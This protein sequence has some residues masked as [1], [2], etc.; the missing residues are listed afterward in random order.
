[1][2]SQLLDW[3]TLLRV[4]GVGPKT[5]LKLLDRFET[6]TAVLGASKAEF[7]DQ[8]VPAKLQQQLQ[9]H[10]PQIAER[11]L[12]W[13]E[14][15]QVKVITL[16]DETY[17]PLLK[18]IHDPPP[19]LFVRGDENL[20]IEPQLAI[21]GSRHASA[22][23]D[24][25]A[26]MFAKALA[27][28]GI[29]VTSGLALGIDAAAHRGAL[30][31]G[32]TVAVLGTG[33]DQIYPK[34]HKTLMADVVEKGCVVSEFPIGTQPLPHNFPR[35]NRIISGLSLGTL[36]VEAAE[37]SGSLVTARMAMEQGREVFAI[38]GSVH[39]PVSRGCH[40][41]IKQGAKLVESVADILEE[42]DV[43]LR[44]FATP[45]KN[46]ETEHTTSAQK[47]D[48]TEQKVLEAVDFYATPMDKIILNA[49][50]ATDKVSVALTQLELLGLVEVEVGGYR[51]KPAWFE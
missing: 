41:L 5:Y 33:I 24:E 44:E 11:D 35:R 28:I 3:L 17:P 10:D 21:V 49:E 15:N 7:N 30:Q 23:G 37:K 45:V 6:P 29:T 51:R 36:V 16:H 39:N 42:I 22:V 1:M 34:R 48:E 38:P 43:Q 14:Q 46:E 2:Q 40:K 8:G 18:E 31:A 4:S 50:L 27:N 12:A 9:Q 32:S 13:I 47:L 19:L 26:H 25:L 20:L